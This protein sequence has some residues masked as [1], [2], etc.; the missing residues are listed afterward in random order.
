MQPSFMLRK[1]FH[2][3]LMAFSDSQG[4]TTHCFSGWRTSMKMHTVAGSDWPAAAAELTAH[5]IRLH[6]CIQGL[7][8]WE[9][10]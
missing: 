3:S 2:E 9:T 1:D 7:S 5:F 6:L 4:A 8:I 10:K